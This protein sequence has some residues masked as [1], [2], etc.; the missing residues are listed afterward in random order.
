MSKILVPAELLTGVDEMDGQHEHLFDEMR[1]VKE[2]FLA[3]EADQ[4]AALTLMSRLAEDLD[5]HFAWEEAAARASGIP[6]ESH[7]REHAK[8]GAFVRAKLGEISSG[9]CNIPALMVYMERC[10]ETHVL[11]HDLKLGH[12][13]LPAEALD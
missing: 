10:F 12:D 3:V 5:A 11:H 2:A 8:I 6:F 13:L 4:G 1:Q 9:D 7:A